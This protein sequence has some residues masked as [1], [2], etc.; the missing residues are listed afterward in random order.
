MYLLFLSLSI[1]MITGAPVLLYSAVVFAAT[2]ATTSVTA[3]VAAQDD[4]PK[5]LTVSISARARM[6]SRAL[7]GMVGCKAIPRLVAKVH[8][9]CVLSVRASFKSSLII[10]Q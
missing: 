3:T 9:S 10:V 8:A 6:Y 4:L 2:K 7:R 1:G 5:K